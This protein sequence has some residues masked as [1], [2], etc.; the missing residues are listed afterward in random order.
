MRLEKC[1]AVKVMELRLARSALT[2]RERKRPEFSPVAY[3]PGSPTEYSRINQTHQQVKLM[4]IDRDQLRRQLAEPLAHPDLAAL[5]D[6]F[7]LTLDWLLKHNATLR[8]QGIGRRASRADMEALLREPPPENGKDFGEV[9]R[10]FD[11]KVAPN[12]FRTNHPR[13]LAFI[14]GAPTPVSVVGDLLCAGTN[15]FAGV[16]FE[17]AGA[18]QVELIVL[19]WFKEF[20]GLPTETQGLLTGGGSEANLTA[21]VI[22]RERV[23]FPDRERLVLYVGEHRHWSVDRA[24][25]IMGLRPEQVRPVRGATPFHLDSQAVADAVHSDRAAG[26]LP[27]LVV[28]NAGATNTGSVDPLSRLADLCKAERLW[29]HVDAAYG[30][31]AALIPE[32]KAALEGIARAD[33]LTLDPH[34]WFGQAFEAGCLLVRDGRRL[35]ETFGHH[36]EYLQ[37]V[38]AADNEVNFCRSRRGPDAPLSRPENLALHQGARRRLVS[39]AGGALLPAGGPRA[40]MPGSIALF[41]GPL[42]P[43]TEHCVFSL[44]AAGKVDRRHIAQPAQPGPGGGTACHRPGVHFL[45]DPRQAGGIA[46]LLRQLADHGGGCGGSGRIAGGTGAKARLATLRRSVLLL[47]I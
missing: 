3:A 40:G 45:D 13:F 4:T 46:F 8:E 30:W 16:W 2:S 15:F 27:W 28:A 7:D 36:P 44:R 1:R 25:K 24:A 10:E 5:R 11:V 23:S 42:S 38:A 41:R 26:R 33:S 39:P 43:A 22:A 6:Y 14:P 9:L 34:K 18:A 37:D 20:L 35:E 21:L 31:S 12:C 32:G 47:N 17:A 19:D 29:F